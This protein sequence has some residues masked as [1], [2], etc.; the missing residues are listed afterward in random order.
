MFERVLFNIVRDGVAFFTEN[1]ARLALFFE[2]QR[3]LSAAEAA[4]LR[5][6]FLAKPPRVQHGFAMAEASLPVY[7][8][9]LESESPSRRF[10]GDQGHTYVGRANVLDGLGYASG[11]VPTF[12]ALLTSTYTITVATENNPDMCIFLHELLKFILTRARDTWIAEGALKLEWSSSGVSVSD[13]YNPHYAFERTMSVTIDSEF[14][15]PL[16]SATDIV[17][18]VDGIYVEGATDVTAQVTPRVTPVVDI[19]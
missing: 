10:L 4:A 15:A 18:S 1:P 7:C 13:K 12:A 19:T 5:T 6:Q 14:L 3:G 16:P 2:F 9:E 17:R 11:V 8:I